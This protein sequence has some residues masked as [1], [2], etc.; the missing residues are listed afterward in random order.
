VCI[1]TFK[2]FIWFRSMCSIYL[3][4]WQPVHP[5]VVKFGSWQAQSISSGI[6]NTT[7]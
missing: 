3:H 6:A 1:S 4:P 2:Q 5:H 7:A